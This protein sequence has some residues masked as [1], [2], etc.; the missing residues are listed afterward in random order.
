[1]YRPMYEG[2]L[3]DGKLVPC[4][5][6]RVWELR[7]ETLPVGNDV[8]YNLAH[9][10]TFATND[11]LNA[12]L[13]ERYERWYCVYPDYAK[14]H[15]ELIEQLK[16]NGD[17]WERM[18]QTMLIEYNPIHNYDMTEEET[19]TRCGEAQSTSRRDEQT[20]SRVDNQ[21]FGYNSTEATDTARETANSSTSGNANQ[22][23]RSRQ[24]GK[25]TLTRAGN[26]GVTTSSALLREYREVQL[27]IID[28]Y[29]SSFDNLFM[30]L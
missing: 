5:P 15:N 16:A 22:T 12:L 9:G 6:M 13:Y 23:D 21:Q 3:K 17:Y 29:L 18:F 25:R 28:M 7:D 24:Q 1:M 4:R 27:K 11:E 2:Y 30:V 10:V 14:M 19:D 8:F 20:G 26:I